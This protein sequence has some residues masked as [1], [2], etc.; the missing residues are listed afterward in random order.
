MH[1]EEASESRAAVAVNMVTL[2]GRICF[3]LPVGNYN[4]L[5]STFAE[6]LNGWALGSLA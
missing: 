5:D 4:H 2:I 6:L 3:V 1:I